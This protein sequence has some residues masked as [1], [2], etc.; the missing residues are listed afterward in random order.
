MPIRLFI[1]HS[2]SDSALAKR[3]LDLLR[4]SLNIPQPE[5]RCT[6]VNGYKLPI[7]ADIADQ[8][9]AEV[10]KSDVL[11]ALLTPS[12]LRSSYVLFELGAR[13]GLRRPMF[14][15][16]AGGVRPSQA[17]VWLSAFHG[18]HC[19]SEA[20]LIQ[21]V[22]DVGRE[23]GLPSVSPASYHSVVVDISNESKR[24]EKEYAVEHGVLDTQM[25]HL[26]EQEM[27]TEDQ[28]LFDHFARFWNMASEY[29]VKSFKARSGPDCPATLQGLVE[30][31]GAPPGA[32]TPGTDLIT[33]PAR[34][35]LRLKQDQRRVWQFVTEI[36]PSRSPQ[37][38]GDVWTHSAIKPEDK[39]Q[40]FHASRRQLAGFFEKWPAIVGR[41]FIKTRFGSRLDYVLLLSWWELA[42]VQWTQQSGRGKQ[43]LFGLAE[44]MTE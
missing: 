38:I 42:L 17:N 15:L 18:V 25:Q 33:W 1:S 27:T 41:R 3:I 24:I 2:A 29:F 12:S 8:I 16:F 35:G 9:K 39:A 13:W 10:F 44:Y 36:Y 5:I 43:N 22:E 6:S 26:K 7:G 23:L 30:A 21:L 11:L 19:D 28:G 20:E 34:D 40:E 14:P 4:L 37:M 32:M 31:T